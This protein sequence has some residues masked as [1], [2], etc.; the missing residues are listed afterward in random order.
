MIRLLR[1]QCLAFAV[2]IV[3][4]C[5]TCRSLAVVLRPYL[6]CPAHLCLH[7]LCIL[8]GKEGMVLVRLSDHSEIVPVS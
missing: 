6:P 3:E 7:L 8:E 2:E 1:R 4:V 5:V